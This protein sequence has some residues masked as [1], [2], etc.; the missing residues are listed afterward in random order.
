MTRTTEDPAR[1][2][3]AHAEA[4]FRAFLDSVL[5]TE[6]LEQTWRLLSNKH[7]MRVIE[8]VTPDDQ[9]KFVNKINQVCYLDS[10]SSS[11]TISPHT[12]LV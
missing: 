5:Q 4:L 2:T 1:H 7:L 3:Y 12:G 10:R 9:K 8:K 11:S 6:Q